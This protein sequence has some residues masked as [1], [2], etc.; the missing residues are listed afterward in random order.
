MNIQLSISLLAS[1]RPAALE[2]CLDSLKPLLMQVP[3]E[4]IVIVTGTDARVR[5]I[6]SKYTNQI[7][8][9][10]WC[11]DFSAARN[12]GLKAAKGEWF[13][14]LDDDEWFDDVEEIRDFFLTGEYKNYGTAFYKVR[15]YL[16]WDGIRYFDFYA[17]R[18]SKLTAAV[19]FQNPI[20][21]ELVPRIGSAKFFES[22]VHHYGYVLNEKKAE[23]GK[24][25]RNIPMLL[26]N[27]RKK[28]N[29]IK[30]Y[31]QLIQEYYV[32]DD[33]DKAE[34]YC[35]KARNMCRGKK[36]TDNYIQWLQVYW[37]D[38]QCKKS[39]TETAKYEITSILEKEKP[40]ELVRLCLYSRLL[41]LC[42]KLETHEETL[43]YGRKFESLLTY[44]EDNPYL[45][46]EQSYGDINEGK[47]KNTEKLS[48][49]RL[50]CVEAALHLGNIEE[51]I[52]FLKLLPWG[53]EAWLQKYYSLFDSWKMQYPD[54]FK[55]AIENLSFDNAYLLFQKAMLNPDMEKQKKQTTLLYCMKQTIS[56]F[57]RLQII[58]EAILADMA[59]TDYM[60]IINLDNWKQYMQQ[61]IEDT[62]LSGL[63]Q[64]ENSAK[65]L[66]NAAPPYGFWMEKYLL[67]KKL[68]RTHLAGHELLSALSDYA[69]C[70]L[71]YY[72]GLYREE[73]FQKSRWNLLPDDCK[74]ALLTSD[75]L[76]NI[77][78]QR[79]TESVKA[80]RH[81]L[82]FYP[83]LTGAVH[84]VIRYLKNSMNNP[85]SNAGEEFQQIAEQMKSTLALLIGQQQYKEAV[86]VM[87]Q[88]CRL[89][90][91]DLE[92]LRLR[93][94]LLLKL[95]DF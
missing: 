91:E 20:H 31:L 77:A 67:E 66:K 11:N 1:D 48:M 62:P 43:D 12:I 21:E 3:S 26:Q 53:D 46:I 81:A 10:T 74:F 80:F 84:E 89:L 50:R 64:I 32:K 60:E 87:E 27:I 2:R 39:D 51:T 88:L 85:A 86:S 13:L 14:Y 7:I 63:M 92:L 42:T 35:R 52:Y 61:L 38:I 68:M 40:C 29:Y 75:A 19:R 15:N 95:N 47:I 55:P 49:N 72:K 90:P 4:L 65:K 18:M 16:N 41:L 54:I 37:A 82:P 34:E 93:Q 70:I 25:S 79:L 58:K 33:F 69:E 6:A 83:A 76:N 94:E 56:P 5:E 44:V 57:L 23:S 36:G 45:W 22:Y 59:L 24:S 28:P 9:F 73:L 78:K 8:P 30:N 17:F 71:S